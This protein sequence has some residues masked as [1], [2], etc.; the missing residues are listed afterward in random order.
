MPFSGTVQP[1]RQDQNQSK[2]RVSWAS[3]AQ[4]P[5]VPDLVVE[6]TQGDART[7]WR[8]GQG[9]Q[10][11]VRVG[12]S[13][14]R[15]TDGK[16]TT[17]DPV[18]GLELENRALA[19]GE[20][21]KGRTDWEAENEIEVAPVIV[22]ARAVPADILAKVEREGLNHAGS[23]LADQGDIILLRACVSGVLEEGQGRNLRRPRQEGR[24][25]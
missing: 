10:S 9:Q 17:H 6:G 19:K 25:G 8:G 5:R 1:L 18:D 20:V 2:A 24:L 23:L 7:H 16:S 3:A 11:V 21:V 13:S 15:V 4:A 12:P 22:E 14:S